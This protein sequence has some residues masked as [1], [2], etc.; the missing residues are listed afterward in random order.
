MEINAIAA[1]TLEDALPYLRQI[2][3]ELYRGHLDL[4]SGASIGEHTRHFIE[5]YQCL[6]EHITA[7]GK[8]IDYARRR[9]DHALE[10][11]P[12]AAQRAIV[13]LVER[14]RALPDD[15]PCALACNEHFADGPPVFIHSNLSREL[16]YNIE[17]T[18]HHMAI[19]KIALQALVP[20]MVLPPHF[21][22][23]PSTIQYREACA[24]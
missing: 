19:I 4:L 2:N 6:L 20:G 12:E 11:D 15:T 16:L 13:A 3:P 9:R 24:Q 5:F 21:G 10:S 1:R 7:E 17:H 18:I 14:I 22:V 23:A 8:I